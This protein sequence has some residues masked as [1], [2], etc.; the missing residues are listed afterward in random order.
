VEFWVDVVNHGLILVIFTVSLNVILGVAGQLVIA[1]AGFGGIG[2]YTAAYLSAKHGWHFPPALA[3]GAGT[4]FLAGL[5]LGAPALRLRLDY[6]ILLTLA[7]AT[8]IVA[9]L[10]AIPVFGGAFGLSG[11]A[12]VTVGDPLL[13]PT[14]LFVLVLPI[15][16]AACLVCWRMASSPYG[17]VLRGIRED[18]DVT[19]ALGKNV[20]S[21]KL[22]T[23]AVTAMIAAVAG[24]VLVYYDRIATPRLFDFNMTTTIVAAAVIGGLGSL[25]GA[26]VGAMLL[27]F[28]GPVLIK[29]VQISP[30]IASLWQNVI[31]GVL[32]VLIMRL[33]P[34][35]LI[36][37]G[38]LSLRRR[39]KPPV[40]EPRKRQPVVREEHPVAAPA[41][42]PALVAR[43]LVK[44]FGGIRAVQ[45][46]D[47]ELMPGR[48][49]ALVGPNG[50]GKTTV[51]NL[52]TGRI[53]PDAG[54]VH[55]FGREI[56]GTPPHRVTRL[57]M[58]RSF[59]DVRTLVRLT[60]LENVMLAVP[61]QPG[62]RMLNLFARP[63]AVRAGESEARERALAA[64]A[65]VG[66]EQRAYEAA[67]GLGYGDQKLLSIARVLA[68]GAEVLLV[69]EPA[70]GIDRKNL[71][72]AL[73]VLERLR[74]EGR[75]ICVVEHNL[76]VVTRLADHVLFM[77]QGR[78][79]ATG[80]MEEITQDR[81]LAE[82]YFGGV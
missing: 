36:P 68:T 55:L 53:R 24:I 19:R 71:D 27:S 38:A 60:L 46:L 81:R 70:A 29:V 9:L 52:V 5:I 56:T 26:A 25:P 63:G 67:G 39:P 45:G 79:T 35:G 61:S 69:D 40:L 12:P 16:V 82:V 10:N 41:A 65:F 66:L 30:N 73:E 62:E 23:F 15:T 20:L 18:D 2:A 37:E 54:T 64:L 44:H 34:N 80:S 22:V 76:D 6:L 13:Q 78:V 7:F 75:T 28:V 47:F 3:A 17:R 72:P 21:F 14:E 74:T 1:P 33:A 8:V 77:E 58:V 4:G 32:V 50:A 51:F 11:I 59:Q 31:Y 48:I 49:T 43:G 42:E 57:G